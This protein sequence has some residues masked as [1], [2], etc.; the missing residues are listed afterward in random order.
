M[1]MASAELSGRAKNPRRK[2]QYHC[3]ITGKATKDRKDETLKFGEMPN[4]DDVNEIFSCIVV[5]HFIRL[6][7]A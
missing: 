5:I 4:E 1:L 2:I 6:L 3:L 7:Q